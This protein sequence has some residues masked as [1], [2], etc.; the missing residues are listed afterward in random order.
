MSTALTK[1]AMTAT[2]PTTNPTASRGVHL[3]TANRK[4]AGAS[5]VSV[6]RT[7]SRMLRLRPSSTVRRSSNCARQSPALVHVR[8]SAVP[9]HPFSQSI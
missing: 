7:R 9:S 1:I 4:G 2:A 3:N 8:P 6:A 5:P